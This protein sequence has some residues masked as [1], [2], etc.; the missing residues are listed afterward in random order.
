LTQRTPD[1]DPEPA[2]G[3]PEPFSGIVRH[4]M[5]RNPRER[6]T[7]PQ[8][9][10]Q[11]HE[12]EVPEAPKRG[13]RTALLALGGVGVLAAIAM[14][15]GLGRERTETPTV[16][17]P[18][19]SAARPTDTVEPA[20]V[21]PQK[22]A[23]IPQKAAVHKTGDWFV[24]VATYAQKGDAEKRAAA[25]SRRFPKFKAETYAPAPGDS[26]PYFL[27]VIG[28]NLSREDAVALQEQARAAGV[29]R[30][31]YVTRFQ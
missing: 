29:A 8:M 20:P 19:A 26:K 27:V 28:S 16:A 23:V 11:L 31:A 10:S 30:D 1:D 24:V 25:I 12:P 18:P 3:L 13:S 7:V 21:I 9:I 14:L 4:S 22:A 6:W 17:V 2:R 15:F 5:L